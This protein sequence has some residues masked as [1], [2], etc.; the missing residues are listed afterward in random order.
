MITDDY[1]STAPN[2]GIWLENLGRRIIIQSINDY[3][4]E[5]IEMNG[6]SRTRETHIQLYAQ[7]LAQHFK[8]YNI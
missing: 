1:Y 3:L 5:I 8:K 4:N 7:S 6:L 2:G